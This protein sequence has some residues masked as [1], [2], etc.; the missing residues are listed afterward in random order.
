MF[1]LAMVLA[2][3]GQLAEAEPWLTQACQ[4]GNLNFL[5]SSL[6]TLLRAGSLMAVHASAYASE[7]ERR[8]STGEK[9]LT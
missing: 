6:T 4:Q 3:R 1:S 8:G 5:R 7:I 9:L 2:E